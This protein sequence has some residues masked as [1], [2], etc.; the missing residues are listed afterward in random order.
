[1][2]ANKWSYFR[3]E[4]PEFH[5]KT[6]RI[7]NCF[8]TLEKQIYCFGQIED[9][10]YKSDEKFKNYALKILINDDAALLPISNVASGKD[11]FCEETSK[12][13]NLKIEQVKSIPSEKLDE[14]Q[15]EDDESG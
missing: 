12:L 15:N 6:F 4:N 13:I 14:N 9:H 10:D 3:I 5:D 11:K 1:M 8:S 2:K 7:W